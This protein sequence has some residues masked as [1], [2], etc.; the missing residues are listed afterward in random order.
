MDVAYA[1][2]QVVFNLKIQPT[3]IQGGHFVMRGKIRR[4][5]YFMYGH[6]F[7]IMPV[8]TSWVGKLVGSTVWAS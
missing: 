5:L 6:A 3:Q 4:R 2:K 1:R 7:G 8:C